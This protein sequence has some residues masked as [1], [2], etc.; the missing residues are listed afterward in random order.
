MEAKMEKSSKQE[1]NIKAMYLR[2]DYLT[3]KFSQ[4][5]PEKLHLDDILNADG[6]SY[7]TKIVEGMETCIFPYKDLTKNE[8]DKF[9]KFAKLLTQRAKEI[10]GWTYTQKF[11]GLKHSDKELEA[12]EVKR[13]S[14]MCPEKRLLE[15]ERRDF[16]FIPMVI[17]L[18]RIFQNSR[19]DME[20]EMDTL[21]QK[22]IKTERQARIQPEEE[23]IEAPE[24]TPEKGA[25]QTEVSVILCDIHGIVHAFN[26]NSAKLFHVSSELLKGK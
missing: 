25:C 23:H 11:S 2:L 21:E 26:K 7:W 1:N 6:I 13:R 19:N 15:A 14:Q 24:P 12:E 20:K 16:S 17:H 9:L 18:K 3:E 10:Y 5:K 4:E 22:L 8:Y